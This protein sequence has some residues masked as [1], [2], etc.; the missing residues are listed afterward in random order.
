MKASFQLAKNLSRRQAYRRARHCGNH[1]RQCI[2][3]FKRYFKFECIQV[4]DTPG[5][6]SIYLVD[7][8]W[9]SL[10]CQTCHVH[11]R[12]ALQSRTV[13]CC[14]R[15]M[16]I[17][18]SQPCNGWRSTGRSCSSSHKQQALSSSCTA[19]ASCTHC[20]NMVTPAPDMSENLLRFCKCCPTRIVIQQG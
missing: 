19:S 5:C 11:C 3:S 12:C 10:S 7:Y 8:T 1:M 2:T 4:A 18:Y 13:V 20:S 16:R 14:C 9:F 6:Q 15:S 17:I